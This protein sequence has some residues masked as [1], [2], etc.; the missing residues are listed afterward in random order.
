MGL[1]VN[2]Y[3]KNIGAPLHMGGENDMERIEMK[4]IFLEYFF[5][6]LV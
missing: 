1:R 6:Y 5:H 3:S 2:G 4:R